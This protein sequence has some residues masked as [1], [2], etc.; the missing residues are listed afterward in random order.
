MAY[1]AGLGNGALV[2]FGA[3]QRQLDLTEGNLSRHMSKLEEAGYL[4]VQKG[5]QGKRPRTWVE[6]TGTGRDALQQHLEA[7]EQLARQAGYTEEKR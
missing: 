7:L 3:L 1:L 4:R 2:E 6:L 5:Y